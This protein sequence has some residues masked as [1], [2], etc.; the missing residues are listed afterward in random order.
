MD[1]V[2]PLA[3][4]VTR[5]I[6]TAVIKTAIRFIM[7]ISARSLYIRLSVKLRVVYGRGRLRPALA[8]NATRKNPARRYP[9]RM[10]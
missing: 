10:L 8:S 4:S 7:K 2:H 6:S 3:L 9:T 1:D 5:T